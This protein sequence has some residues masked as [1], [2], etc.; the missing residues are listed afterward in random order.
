MN[1]YNYLPLSYSK[2][3]DFNLVKSVGKMIVKL[4]KPIKLQNSNIFIKEFID[5]FESNYIRQY[6]QKGEQ[7]PIINEL[8]KNNLVFDTLFT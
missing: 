1:K 3:I 4:S 8:L 2:I 7:I 6:S 5:I